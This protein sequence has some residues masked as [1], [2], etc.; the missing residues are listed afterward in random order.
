MQSAQNLATTCELALSYIA[1]LLREVAFR[2]LCPEIK[3]CENNV[4]PVMHDFISLAKSASF[5]SYRHKM[6]IDE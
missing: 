4:N 5:R 6:S 1:R 3:M 2:F